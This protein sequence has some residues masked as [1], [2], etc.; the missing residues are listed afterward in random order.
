MNALVRK[1]IRLLLPS[2][3]VACGLAYFNQ[4]TP[5]PFLPGHGQMSPYWYLL[6][7]V[8]CPLMV[9]MLALQSFGAEMSS[10]TFPALLAQPVPRKTIWNTKILLLA[11]AVLVIAFFWCATFKVRAT[12]TGYHFKSWPLVEVVGL[13][14]M[15]IVS[16]GLWTVLLLRQITIAFWVTLLIPIGIASSVF[17]FVQDEPYEFIGRMVMIALGVYSI[18]GFLFARRLFLRAQDVQWTGTNI[19]MPEVRGLSRFK[20]R[21]GLR[22]RWSPRM[23]LLIKEF[24]F[25]QSQLIIAAV[26]VL[27]HL[28]IVVVRNNSNLSQWSPIRDVLEHFWILWL[29]MPMLVGGIAVAEERKFGTLDAQLCLPIRRRTQFAVKISVVLLLSVVLGL[30]MPLLLEHRLLLSLLPGNFVIR[31][32]DLAPDWRM[33]FPVLRVILPWMPLL[34]SAGAV[35]AVG[36][37]SFYVSTLSRNTFQALSLAVLGIVLLCLLIVAAANPEDLSPIFAGLA[38]WQRPLLIFVVGVPILVVTFLAL[39]SW[40]YRRSTTT[41]QVCMQNL[42]AWLAA[43]VLFALITTALNYIWPASEPVHSAEETVHLQIQ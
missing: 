41:R 5:N 9:A 12:S 30:V 38:P 10:G 27:L 13:I 3:A 22:R 34:A 35:A 4:F 1:E 15:V 6:P 20:I 43:F 8:L 23:A 39:S 7:F 31:P 14:A 17:C 42:L 36:L 28:A 16:G 26:L 2:F 25:H 11:L 37:V 32:Q 18:A 24:Q 40:N 29:V 19:A 21:S 33:Y